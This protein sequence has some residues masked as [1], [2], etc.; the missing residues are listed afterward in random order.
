VRVGRVRRPGGRSGTVAAPN[1]APLSS[2]RCSKC[3]MSFNELAD[4]EDLVV[5]WAIELVGDCAVVTM[6]TNKLNI[7]SDSFFADLHDALDRLERDFN[8]YPVILTGEGDVFSA[9]DRFQVRLQHHWKWR[10]QQDPRVVSEL[11]R[12][13]SSDFP[14]S[15]TVAAVNGHAIAG[16]LIMALDCDFLNEVPI[17][18]PMPA[19][20]VEIIKYALGEPVGALTSATSCRRYQV[21]VSA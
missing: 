17:G 2:V 21:S 4:L 1:T 18:I 10:S 7:Q 12:Y 13:K 14:V 6:N 19:A 11:P 15:T 16:G 9:G 3:K 5:G 20:H 8:P